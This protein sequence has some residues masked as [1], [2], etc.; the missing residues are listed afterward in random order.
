MS[1]DLWTGGF[2]K[3]PYICFMSFVVKICYNISTFLEEVIMKKQNVLYP[4]AAKALK[5]MGENLRLARRRRKITAS[6]MA[7]RAN[8]S[9]M[10][11]RSLERGSAHVS[12][13][14]YMAVISCLGFQ[15][16]IASVAANDVLGRDL[17]DAAL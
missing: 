9:L 12:M 6:M 8:M 7:E 2:L 15:D 14:N 11:L 17:Q 3:E 13:C 16:D 10:T 5:R 4:K 1:T